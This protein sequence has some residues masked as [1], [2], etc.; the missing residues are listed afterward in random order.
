MAEHRCLSR[1]C[2]Q[3]RRLSTAARSG[4]ARRLWLGAL[5]VVNHPAVNAAR[6]KA[7]H[8]ARLAFEEAA[9][10]RTGGT[11]FASS[12]SPSWRRLLPRRL[13]AG[14]GFGISALLAGT[15]LALL[16]VAGA[17]GWLLSARYEDLLY[18]FEQRQAQA[19]VRAIS[20]ETLWNHHAELA[21]EGA[22]RRACRERSSDDHGRA[23]PS[24]PTR[25]GDAR[26]GQA[27]GPWRV[28]HGNGA[29]RPALGRRRGRLAASGAA[30]RGR[31]S[32]GTARLEL[33]IDGW[34]S[35]GKPYLSVFAPIGGLRPHGYVGVHVGP[36][37][38]LQGMDQ[39]L[40]IQVIFAALG[41]GRVLAELGNVQAAPTALVKSF[42]APITTPG[43]SPLA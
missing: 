9:P 10:S 25:P 14:R 17:V 28:R 19:L 12:L 32:G 41:S 33:F 5:P 2:R 3:G 6:W 38:A 36:L 8:H 30:R 43:G 20:E 1:Q 23:G 15:N 34:T 35:D 22:R 39:R 31:R 24:V 27:P 13:R 16:L 29:P 18:A 4:R 37:W 21:G 42:L 40:G 26:Q 11:W 7:H